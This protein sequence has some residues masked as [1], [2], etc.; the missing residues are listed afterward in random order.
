[1]TPSPLD[2]RT[3]GEVFADLAALCTSPGY[4]HA[5]AFFCFRDNMVLYTGELTPKDMA[6][7]RSPSALTRTEVATL[8]G[9][10][11]QEDIDWTLPSHETIGTYIDKTERLLEEMHQALS[12][13]FFE[14]LQSGKSS[15][16][17]PNPFSSAAMLREPIFYGGDSAYAFQY[18][19]FAPQKYRNDNAWLQRNKGF[20]IDSAMAVVAAMDSILTEKKLSVLKTSS[21]L[22]PSEWTYLPGFA[23][24]MDDVVLQ[25]GLEA[26]LVEAILDSMTLPAGE[27]NASFSTL[28]EFNKTQATPLIRRTDDF[29][30]FQSYGLAEALYESPFYWMAADHEY[31][32]TAF[33][34]RGRFTE[35]FSHECLSRVF[36]TAH[37]HTNV[38]L[39]RKRGGERI[40]EIDVLV[41]FGARAI[42]LQAKSKRLTV[43]AR[44]G[45]DLRLRDDFKKAVQD[46]CDQ[47][48]LCCSALLAQDVQLTGK[49]G[50]SL[51]LP[52]RPKV[53]FPVC[54]VAD[55]YPALAF[56]A[57]QFLGY[58]A[59]EAIPPP[60]ATDVFGLDAITEMLNSPLRVLSYLDLR[61]RFGEKLMQMHEHTLLSYHL[62]N[63]L[64]VDDKYDMMLLGDDIA[65]DLDLAMAVR[66]DGAPGERTPDGILTRLE[67]SW[68]G[69]LIAEIE[70]R[71]EEPIQD[72][73]MLL[74]S[75]N[76][77]AVD[78]INEGVER[79]ISK[80]QESASNHDFGIS[81]GDA[82]TGL[83]VNCNDR[84]LDDALE[85]LSAHCRL[86]KY[87]QR[88][89]T[90]FGLVLAPE[91]GA[92][93][94]GMKLDEPWARNRTLNSLVRRAFKGGASGSVGRPKRIK[95][96]APCPCGSGRKYKNCCG[97]KANS[98]R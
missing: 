35:E 83:T 46:A 26:K 7:L 84:S 16:S 27:R 98:R 68:V 36:G 21:S 67:G 44:K 17:G 3:E 6:N 80:A 77:A 88:A 59:T 90:W 89:D 85:R 38:E 47:A 92:V 2:A 69:N 71:P 20:D 66:R 9:L 55:H 96:N 76:E 5:I 95:R 61:A 51:V 11:V 72:L 64:W 82:S 50:V 42:V 40:G 65:A 62:R 53:A 28:S 10:L 24:S 97:K 22:P 31:A 56:Q 43:E 60:L 73:G 39:I 86:K 52:T 54:I 34:N 94:G 14:H 23:L 75:I 8:V 48:Y 45:N 37:V 13:P 32:F 12:K 57:R 25:T 63:N 41:L 58:T 78:A 30:L 79:I 18:R 1:M 81:F 91:T 33:E 93:R 70:R 29:V 87:Q 19:D 4:A 49:T 74:L 15:S